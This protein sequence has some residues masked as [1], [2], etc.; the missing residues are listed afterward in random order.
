MVYEEER[1]EE[2]EQ[3]LEEFPEALRQQ[4]AFKDVQKKQGL[5]RSFAAFRRRLQD[6]LREGSSSP[7]LGKLIRQVEGQ[8]L[9]EALGELPCVERFRDQARRIMGDEAYDALALE[10]A[11]LEKVEEGP[12]QGHH[13]RRLQFH[14]RGDRRLR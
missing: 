14:Q 5:Y 9:S 13:R 8:R 10:A 6:A 2:A 7:L 1:Y 4:P 12:G 3:L 11:E